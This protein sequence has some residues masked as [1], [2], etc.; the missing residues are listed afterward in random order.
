MIIG[1]PKETK[2]QENRVALTPAGVAALTRSS[3]K[4]LIERGAGTGSGFSDKE[5]ASKGA[6]IVRDAE[7]IFWSSDMVVK[8]KEPIEPEYEMLRP[9]V[10]LFTYLHLAADPSLAKSLLDHRVTSLAYETVQDDYRG[11]PL[12][13][14]MSEIAGRISVQ[15]GAHFLE[16]QHGGIGK[17]LAGV[18]GVP[19]GTVT[20]IGAGMVGSNAAQIAL[21][22]GAKVI[23]IDT[24]IGRLRQMEQFLIGNLV[25][26]AA[27]VDATSRAVAEADLVIGGVLIPGAKAPKVVSRD[28]IS[29]MTPGS[30]VID[31]AVDQGGCIETCKPTTHSDP[32]FLV[33]GVV[34]Y[35][36]TN[37]PGAVPRTSTEAL[38]N[39]S[40]PFIEEIAN[41]GLS[42]SLGRDPALAKGL[43]T[44]EGQVTN[45]AVADSLSLPFQ[46]PKTLG[47]FSSN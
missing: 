45:R 29:R 33:D 14:P 43:N 28:M 24:N 31:V 41:L 34:H 46:P 1:V 22:I 20:V 5:Y 11:L 6:T 17:L 26:V 25:T 36:V 19:P 44:Y 16:K 21:G 9:G 2:D 7:D 8:V 38:C 12:L 39:V 4:V 40:F 35:C 42:E 13:A 30:V 47:A 10:I 32:T 27:G 37:I 18:P 15:I 23:L 3:H